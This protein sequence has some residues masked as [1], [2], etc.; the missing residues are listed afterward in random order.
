MNTAI[1]FFNAAVLAG[2][3]LLFGTLGEILTQKSGNLNLGVEGMM[4]MGALSGLSAVMLLEVAIGSNMDPSLAVIIAILGSFLAGA[5]GALIYSVMVISL[6]AQ[7]NV[8][9]LALTIFGIGFGNFFGDFLGRYSSDGFVVRISAAAQQGFTGITIPFLSDIPVIGTLFFS[10]NILVYLGV[11]L[12]VVLAVFLKYTT[13]GLNLIAVG[14]NP[15]TA[16]AAG[17]NV[18]RYKY[19]ATCIGGGICGIGGMYITMVTTSGRWVDDSVR[20]FGWI[21]VA[22]VIFATWNPWRAL[23]GSLIFGGLSIMR[24]YLPLGI[25]MQLYGSFPYI[26]TILVLIVTSIRQI[27]EHSAPSHLGANYFREER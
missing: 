18:T 19:L 21:A 20:G 17:I 4:F 9:G 27:K 10:Y 16:D 15:A 1:L 2:T 7:Q 24:F 13:W 25:P 12:A 26:A 5:F 6:R 11:I 14:E 8:T 22:L 3:P 23:I